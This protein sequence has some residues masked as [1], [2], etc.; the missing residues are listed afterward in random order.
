MTAETIEHAI[1]DLVGAYG[2]GVRVAREGARVLARL[3]EVELYPGCRPEKTAMLLVF[4]PSQQ[5]PIPH[6]EPGQLLANGRV[7]RST[8][9]VMVGGE[10]WMQFSFNIPWE[11]GISI[12]RFVAA[13]RQRFAQNE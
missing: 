6:V 1:E 10:S 7:P 5:K 2:D 4:D 3:S 13:A 12:I 9:T 11:E 8:S